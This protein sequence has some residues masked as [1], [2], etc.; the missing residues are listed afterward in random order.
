[1]LV[2]AASVLVLGHA[3]Q[4]IGTGFEMMSTGISTLMPQ[5]MS[6]ATTIGGLVLLIPAIQLLG[7]SLMGLSASLIAFGVAGVL[8]APGLMAIAAVGAVATG[9]NSLLGGGDEG[10]GSDSDLITEIRGLR[11]DLNNG[12]VAVYL[13]GQRVTAGVS[14]VVSRVGSNSYAT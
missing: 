13:D 7:L 12:K 10:G 3:L 9:I 6:V 2:I 14:K 4:A 5:L 1:M 8:A 11:E